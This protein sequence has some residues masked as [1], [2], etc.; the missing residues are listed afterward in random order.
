MF[1]FFLFSFLNKLTL[2]QNL[3]KLSHLYV[4]PFCVFNA[5]YS[6]TV[7][8]NFASTL[9][10]RNCN[11][12]STTTCL[13]WNKRNTPGK[14]LSGLSSISAWTWPPALS[15]LKRYFCP[16]WGLRPSVPPW[17]RVRGCHLFFHYFA[18]FCYKHRFGLLQ[19]SITASNNS[20]L[21]SPTRSCSSSSIT[22]C[23]SWNRR[24]TLGR[25]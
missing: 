18:F 10:T 8:S 9:P 1:T 20:A 13:C 7:S 15:S 21:T 12:F 22:T 16:R 14:E 6:S 2:S 23:S 19:Y 5:V 3:R 25:V 11:S 24:N 17:A 4:F